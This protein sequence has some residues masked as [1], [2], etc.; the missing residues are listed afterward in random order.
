MA[1]MAALANGHQTAETVVLAA[2]H[3]MAG[4]VALALPSG[5]QTVEMA[6]LAFAS[7]RRMAETADPAW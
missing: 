4:M 2:D 6:A 5:R 3:P 1:E 7:V